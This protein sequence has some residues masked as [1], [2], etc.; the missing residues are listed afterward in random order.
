LRSTVFPSARIQSRHSKVS[1]FGA[2]SNRQGG[3]GPP[4][5]TG[6]RAARAFT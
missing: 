2:D 4:V 5:R 3:E 1:L 6:G